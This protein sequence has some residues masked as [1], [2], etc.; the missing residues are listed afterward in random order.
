MNDSLKIQDIHKRL[1]GLSK[2]SHLNSMMT[3]SIN[4]ALTSNSPKTIMKSIESSCR[5][6]IQF[7]SVL[8]LFDAFLNLF[9]KSPP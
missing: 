1:K 3:E 7:E 9:L 2:T 5:N 4:L 6:T 8:Q